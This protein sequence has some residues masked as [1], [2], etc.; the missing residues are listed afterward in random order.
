MSF[1]YPL[2]LLFPFAI[3]IIVVRS[4]RRDPALLHASVSFLDRLPVSMRV[5]LRKP[6]L[7]VLA[8]MFICLLSLAAAR[9]QL[10]AFDSEKTESRNIMLALDLS[11]SMRTHDF[12]VGYRPASRLEAVKKVVKQFINEREGDR[13]GLV[14]FGSD[15]FLQCPLTYDHSLL[16][17]IVGELQL[18]VAGE[19]TAIGDGLGLSLKRLYKIDGHSK[20]VILL[21]D[22]VNTS[23]RVSPLQAA[24]VARDLEIKVHTI[25]I[26]SPDTARKMRKG[27]LTNADLKRYEYD[28]RTLA[29]MA[30]VSGGVYFNA[31]DIEKLSEVYREIDALEKSG[32]QEPKRIVLRELFPE[33][34]AAALVLFIFHMLLS[35]SIFMRIP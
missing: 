21:T 31:S 2:A 15:A 27:S 29:E 28:A 17:Q 5:R 23:G 35:D 24:K 9:P 33:F 26:G 4:A 10:I 1:A 18:G 8:G 3:L 32:R 30:E 16:A 14:V 19:K 13:L 11:G 20:A 7:S 25:G 22:G 12:R 34:A 6:L